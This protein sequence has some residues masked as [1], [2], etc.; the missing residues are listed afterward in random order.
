MHLNRAFPTMGDDSRESAACYA[1]KVAKAQE[2]DGSQSTGAN[3]PWY[4]M[5]PD[6]T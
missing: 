6:T 1:Q 3:H 5:H 4:S 2:K